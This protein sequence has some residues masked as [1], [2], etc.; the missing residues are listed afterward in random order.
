MAISFVQWNQTSSTASVS[1]P[2]PTHVADDICIMVVETANQPPVLTTPAGFQHIGG[3]GIGA[4]GGLSSSTGTRMDLYWCR[5]T[6]SSM[7]SPTVSDDGGDHVGVIMFTARGC[8]TVGEPYDTSMGPVFD[9]K[10]TASTTTTWPTTSTTKANSVPVFL[11]V[12]PRDAGTATSWI[13]PLNNTPVY[14]NMISYYFAHGWTAGN[15]GQF[16]GLFPPPL[17][18]PG[19]VGVTTAK[20]NTSLPDITAV[21]VLIEV[22]NLLEVSGSDAGSGADAASVKSDVPA[23]DTSAAAEPTPTIAVRPIETGAVTESARVIVAPTDL[24]S[25]TETAGVRYSATVSD[26]AAAVDDAAASSRVDAIEAGQFT[27]SAWVTVRASEAATGGDVVV[28]MDIDLVAQDTIGATDAGAP[29]FS[30][31]DTAQGTDA[32]RLTVK[33]IDVGAATDA[34]LLSVR[35]AGQD[36]ATG[37]DSA[38][39]IVYATTDEA[40]STDGAFIFIEGVGVVGARVVRVLTENRKLLCARVVHG[41]VKQILAERRVRVLERESRTV[42]IATPSRQRAIPSTDV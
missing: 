36:V 38:R 17:A 31:P 9:T 33:P 22:P 15:G 40:S 2:W 4:A 35:Q 25:T 7:P 11:A 41:G 30:S 34:A 24:T 42:P 6:S 21:L 39:V 29:R 1:A 23:T 18:T 16:L 26:M 8:T 37:T 3:I 32:S 13:E 12:N 20:L 5:A 14:G 28:P 27:E 10:T 19:S